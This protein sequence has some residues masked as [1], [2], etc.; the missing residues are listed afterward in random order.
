MFSREVAGFDESRPHK[1]TYRHHR[2]SRA[3]AVEI[4]WLWRELQVQA[5]A[6]TP[7][8]MSITIRHNWIYND[9]S[10]DF[11]NNEPPEYEM[12][13]WIDQYQ[14]VPHVRQ[15]NVSKVA[16]RLETHKASSFFTAE[17]IAEVPDDEWWRNDCW[18]IERHHPEM[19]AAAAHA[20]DVVCNLWDA[21]GFGYFT[22]LFGA[23]A[24]VRIDRTSLT[25]TDEPCLL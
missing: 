20:M 5:F 8:L 14:T 11:R 2:P 25:V 15:I 17:Q 23:A 1:G 21:L 9:N 10:H 7:E 13:M 3:R 22:R 4:E 24:A 12:A 19:I 18:L 16:V 6:K